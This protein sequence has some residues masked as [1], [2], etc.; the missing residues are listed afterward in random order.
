MD[1]SP[2]AMVR[3]EIDF[4]SGRQ[5]RMVMPPAGADP[6][7]IVQALGL[8][9]PDAL[10]LIFGGADGME[11]QAQ[12]RIA[13]LFRESLVPVAIARRALIID[14]GTQSGIMQILGEVIAERQDSPCALGV[15]PIE[16]VTYPG[17]TGTAT[18]A[19]TAALDPNHSHFILTPTTEWGSETET[20]FDVTA[21]LSDCLSESFE[22]RPR[23]VALLANGGGIAKEEA[24]R[25]AWQGWNLVILAG[26]GRVADEIAEAHARLP[27]LPADPKIR[28]IIMRSTVTVFPVEAEPAALTKLLESLETVKSRR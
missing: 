21:L 22:A 24:Y 5:A 4:G 2:E 19:H 23:V 28:D 7:T 16:K 12:T 14:G 9:Q 27:A 20:I 26:T 15:A 13:R 10:M 11:A 18:G 1:L 3:Q 17:K 6:E 25:C 8:E